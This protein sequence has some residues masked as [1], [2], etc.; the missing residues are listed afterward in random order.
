M[1]KKFF[2]VRQDERIKINNAAFWHLEEA[3]SLMKNK[4]TLDV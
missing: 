4:E 3:L 2:N 1:E